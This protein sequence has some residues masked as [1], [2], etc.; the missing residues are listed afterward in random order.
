MSNHTKECIPIG[1]IEL[2]LTALSTDKFQVTEEH[3]QAQRNFFEV[4]SRHHIKECIPR[5]SFEFNFTRYKYF[6]RNKLWLS[7]FYGTNNIKNII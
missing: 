5:G 2:N 1:C 3:D 6:S 7:F 4:H